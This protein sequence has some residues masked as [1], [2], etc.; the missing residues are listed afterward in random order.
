MK[1]KKLYYFLSYTW[2]LP[3]NL[4]GIIVEIFLK[5]IF[6]IRKKPLKYKKYGPCRV[7]EIGK[8]R[9]G[10]LDLGHVTLTNPDPSI[11]TLNHEFGHTLQNIVFGPFFIFIVWLPSAIRYNVRNIQKKFG[12]QLP[13]YDSIWFEGSATRLGDKYIDYYK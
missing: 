12:K 4:I 9:W 2:G 8:T 5:I 3:M 10:G 11:H 13:P 7:Y 6:K 1:N